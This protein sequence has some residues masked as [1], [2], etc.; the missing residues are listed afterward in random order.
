[1]FWVPCPRLGVGMSSIETWPLR[2]VAMA[3]AEFEL[4]LQYS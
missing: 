3:P 1:M 4:M 2:A